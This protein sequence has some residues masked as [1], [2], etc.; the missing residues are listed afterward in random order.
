MPSQHKQQRDNLAIVRHE[1]LIDAGF[2]FF[3]RLLALVTAALAKL[4]HRRPRQ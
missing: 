1:H 4:A 3:F 2:Q